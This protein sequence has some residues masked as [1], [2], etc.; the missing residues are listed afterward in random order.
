MYGPKNNFNKFKKNL[1]VE[2][3]SIASPTSHNTE[4]SSVNMLEWR[5]LEWQQN[6]KTTFF[7]LRIK[8]YTY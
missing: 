3:F 5:P 8:I 6:N 4:V 2:I 7:E 1:N